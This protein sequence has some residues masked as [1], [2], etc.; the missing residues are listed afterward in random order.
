MLR[1]FVPPVPVSPLL[2]VFELFELDVRLVP[3]FQPAPVH[4]ILA[5][6]PAV[7]VLVIPV[8]YPPFIALVP[9]MVPIILWP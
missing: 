4:S 8:V 5:I 3:I 2:F 9:L 7:I 1:V 6:V